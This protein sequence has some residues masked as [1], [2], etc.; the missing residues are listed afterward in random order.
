M[1]LPEG[2]QEISAADFFDRFEYLCKKNKIKQKE[3]A[4]KLGLKNEQT[5]TN[6][7]YTN[8]L[9]SLQQTVCIAQ[10]LNCSL[11]YL[12]FGHV[13]DTKEIEQMREQMNTL[14]GDYKAI[15]DMISENGLYVKKE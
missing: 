1:K 9:P 11:D 14:I 2:L 3:I 8:R 7:K 12:V 13:G 5:I 10:L 15:K 6:W 4:E